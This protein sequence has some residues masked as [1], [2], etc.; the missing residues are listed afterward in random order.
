MNDNKYFQYPFIDDFKQLPIEVWRQ[1]SGFKIFNVF[2]GKW[3][4]C[5]FHHLYFYGV[6]IFKNT[7]ER[8]V[9]LKTQ[10]LARSD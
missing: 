4:K 1:K 2:S 10:L 6:P 5:I 9:R 7:K 3:G 8:Y